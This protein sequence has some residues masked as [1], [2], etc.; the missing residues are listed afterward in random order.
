MQLIGIFDSPYVRR[1]AISLKL[2]GLPF[3]HRPLSVLRNFE[4]FRRSNPMVKAP[5]LVCDDGEMLCESTLI[6]DYLER[7]AGKSLM[8]ADA[9]QHRQGLRLLGIALTACDKTVQ[10]M[11]ERTQRPPQTLHQ[12]W[13]DRLHG[14]LAEACKLLETA[15]MTARPWL[16]GERLS[17]ADVTIAVAWSA[18]QYYVAD[19]IKPAQYPVLA[20]WTA[21]AERL[22][23]FV[24]TPMV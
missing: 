1:T 17:Q 8:P 6:L 2:L 3:E 7:L 15:A 24:S 9:R 14:Q 23:E 19:L 16:L 20:A 21:R 13:L 4:E 18:V 5:T 11:Y 22:P 10:I 12:P